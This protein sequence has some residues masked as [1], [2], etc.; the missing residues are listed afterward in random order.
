MATQHAAIWFY[1]DSNLGKVTENNNINELSS[2]IITSNNI[3]IT[4]SAEKVAVED[5]LFKYK[6]I[7]FY[8]SDKIMPAWTLFLSDEVQTALEVYATNESRVYRLN[9]YD[10]YPY[11]VAV[12]KN[13][14]VI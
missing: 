9:W 7:I 11:Y 1:L 8:S 10:S 13:G 14:L 4:S 2:K 12:F 5:V 6:Y 3:E